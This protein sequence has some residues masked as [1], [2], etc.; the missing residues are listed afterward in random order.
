MV[1]HLIVDKGSRLEK[2]QQ[3]LPQLDALIAAESDLIANL[4]NVTAAIQ[5]TFKFLWVGFY[6][7]QGDELILGPFQGPIACT[8]IKIGAGVC[9]RAWIDNRIIVVPNVDEFEGHIACSS[10]SRS[11]IVVPICDEAGEVKWVLDIDSEKLNNF[12]QTDTDNLQKLARILSN[13]L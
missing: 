9:G 7:V 10:A 4:A 1:E 5:Q 8:R 2:Y 11:E 13:L 6:R 12:D 3:L